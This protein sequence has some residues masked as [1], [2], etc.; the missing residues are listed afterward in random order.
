MSVFNKNSLVRVSP[1]GSLI[2]EGIFD[3]SGLLTRGYARNRRSICN[4]LVPFVSCN[5]RFKK[6]KKKKFFSEHGAMFSLHHE[7]FLQKDKC[8][9]GV[10]NEVYLR[11]FFTDW[12]N[13]SRRI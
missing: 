13:F 5:G 9:Y 7:F 12:C 3:C 1:S 8:M 11:N 10:L 4:R 6:S 2:E